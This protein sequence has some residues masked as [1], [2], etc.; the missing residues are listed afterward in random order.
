MRKIAGVTIGQAPRTDMTDDLE[1][2]LAPGLELVQFGAL[3]ALTLDE[4]E[5][6]LSPAPG[7]E[8]LVSRMRDGRQATMGAG[9]LMPLI[10]RRIRDAEEAGC[11][12]VIL[13][14]TGAF[15]PLAH[16]VP[17]VFPQRLFNSVARELA[18]GRPVAVMVPEAA[19]VEDARARWAQIGLETVIEH[20][21]PY[22]GAAGVEAAAARLRGADAAF[23]CLDCMGYTTRM[24]ALAREASGLDVLLPRTLVASVVSELMG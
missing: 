22:A 11:D 8:V 16:R 10:E 19:Q 23:L 14:C 6:D 9:R 5:R 3:D 7:E 1:A 15:P 13:L 24:R 4:V 18:G 20:A 17:L 12:A 21:S 2:R